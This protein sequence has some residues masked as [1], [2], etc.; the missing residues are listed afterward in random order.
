MF[1]LFDLIGKQHRVSF[2]KKNV[3]LKT[4]IRQFGL[5]R[6]GGALYFVT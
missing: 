3:N 5:W 1:A 4:N 2:V 6:L